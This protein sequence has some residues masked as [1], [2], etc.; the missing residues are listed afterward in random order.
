VNAKGHYG[1]PLY[2]SVIEVIEQ[3]NNFATLEDLVLKTGLPKKQIQGTM[4]YLT[5]KLGIVEYGYSIHRE[6]KEKLP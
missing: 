4:K 6:E 5:G 1:A 3:Q 2:V